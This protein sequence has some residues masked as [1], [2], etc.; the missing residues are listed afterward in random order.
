MDWLASRAIE[1]QARFVKELR[2]MKFGVDYEN[3]ETHRLL[4]KIMTEGYTFVMN[5]KFC[6]L[7]SGASATIPAVAKFELSWL[8]TPT[9]FM[10]L[11]KPLLFPAKKVREVT[12][13]EIHAI[14]WNVVAD[15]VYLWCLIDGA[16][17]N[18]NVS[19]LLPWSCT[20]LIEGTP[21]SEAI[22]QDHNIRYLSSDATNEVR[23]LYTAFYIMAQKIAAVTEYRAP[24]YARRQAEREGLKP[25]APYRVVTLRRLENK[26]SGPNHTVVDWQWQWV[27]GWHWR[28]QYFPSTGEHKPVLI[29][30]YVKGP[31]EKPLKP[32]THTLYVAER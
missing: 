28:N 6:D 19:G 25:P 15:I 7:V 30:P 21:L 18:Q 26:K 20:P 16:R 8:G 9:G 11:E 10:Y 12:V 24:R 23:W 17:C 3:N 5:D 13:S 4:T 27:V 1:T 29:A 32:V 14:G 22:V 2:H 31:E